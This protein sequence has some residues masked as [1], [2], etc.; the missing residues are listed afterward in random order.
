MFHF[1]SERENKHTKKQGISV[2]LFAT[3]QW[4]KSDIRKCQEDKFPYRITCYSLIN[5]MVLNNLIFSFGSF[6]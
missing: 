1:N 3:L 6:T 5:V 4:N 2:L